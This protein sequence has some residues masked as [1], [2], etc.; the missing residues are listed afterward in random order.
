MKKQAKQLSQGCT[1]IP[2][3]QCALISKF[4]ITSYKNVHEQPCCWNLSIRKKLHSIVLL[5][6]SGKSDF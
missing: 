3:K 5:F 1:E 2:A 4:V 6:E